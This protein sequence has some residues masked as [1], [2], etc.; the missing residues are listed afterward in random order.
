M[1]AAACL[2]V[3][4]IGV[5]PGGAAGTK[6]AT[7]E[8]TW[9]SLAK[10]PV[11]R[12]F[13]DAKFGIFIHWGPYSVAAFRPGGRGYAEHFPQMLYRD[14]KRHYPFMKK[15]FG[16]APPA[17]GYK[18]L[19]PRFRAEKFDPDAWADLFV[20]AGARYVIPTGE[21]HD[22]F[23]LWDSKLTPWT[24]ARMGPKRDL[25][26]D[27][28]RAVRRRGLKFGVSYHRERHYWFFARKKKTNGSPPHADVAEEIRRMPAAAGLYGPFRLDEPYMAD[29]VRRWEEVCE[30]YRPDFMWL[31]DYPPTSRADEEL[32]RAYCVR[33]IADYLNRA[34]A[35]GQEVY[36]NNKGRKPNWPVDAGCREKDNLKLPS[37]G[38]KWQ[39][40]ATLGT[41]YGY[42]RAEEQRDAYK[43]PTQLIH[44][45][46][47]V[48]SKNGN[49]LL[50]IGP[51]ADGTIPEAQRR[52]LLAMGRWL[53]VNGEAIYGT[54]PWTTFGQ[55][56]P[57]LRFTTRARTLYAIALAKGQAAF[58]IAST[59]GWKAEDVE[60]VSLLGCAGKV[61]WAVT[62][63]GLAVTPP[64]GAE[65]EHAWVFRVQSRRDLPR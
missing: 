13:D 1:A 36:F 16:L 63:A 46:C 44:L 45:L 11:P 55:S 56:A 9:E 4:L 17:F 7:Y 30:K 65:G 32:Y 22:G 31:D 12:W 33:M 8:A 2:A 60:R 5:A 51:R 52:R 37:I 49:L 3:C 48:V 38:P 18:D 27:L 34:R 29:Y 61:G 26:G 59:K 64:P 15:A 47:D 53:R 28:A 40:P 19:I 21:H 24:A 43:S 20:R 62:E 54:R 25:I 14:P 39:N 57:A 35:W 58:T 50:N 6:P 41:S 10:V 42:M 23:V